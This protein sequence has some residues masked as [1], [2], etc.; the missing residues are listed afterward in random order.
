[1]RN[2]STKQRKLLLDLLQSRADQA[3]SAS[4]IAGLLSGA[5]ISVS[6]VYRN[7]S[8]LEEQGKIH[9]V[10][11]AGEKSAFYRYSA[12]EQCRAH[13]HVSCVKCGRTVHVDEKTTGEILKSVKNR[14]GFEVD[15]SSTMLYGVCKNCRGGKAGL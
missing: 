13:L 3:L 11:V 6:S 9:R 5:G 4:E 1:M 2:Y 10:N 14:A 8:A 15:S 12:A 7:L